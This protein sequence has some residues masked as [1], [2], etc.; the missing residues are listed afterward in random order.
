MTSRGRG[1]K[2]KSGSTVTTK[3]NTIMAAFERQARKKNCPVCNQSIFLTLYRAHLDNCK[4]TRNDSD[5]EVLEVLTAEESR[6]LRAGSPIVIET[7]DA[8][9]PTAASSRR[10]S[11]SKQE[12]SSERRRSKRIIT[13]SESVEEIEVIK[14]EPNTSVAA[15]PENHPPEIKRRS[16]SDSTMQV[17]S[18]KRT[19]RTIRCTSPLLENR[20]THSCESGEACAASSSNQKKLVTADEVV[21]KI[22]SLLNSSILVSPKKLAAVQEADGDASSVDV[23]R[24]PYIVKFTL[25]MMRRV[26]LAA[27]SDGGRYD[28]TF[29]GKDIEIFDRFIGL[30]KSARELFMRMHLRKPWWLTVEKLK[31]RYAELSPT[32]D[33]ALKELVDSGFV[34]SDKY[35]SSLEE[36][37]KIAPLPVLRV[38]AKKYQLDITK[39]KIELIST[40]RNFSAAQKGLFGQMGTVTVAMVKTVK[41]ELGSCYRINRNVSMTFKALF[42][43]YVP[44]EMCS[45]L[46]IDQPSLNLS[47]NLLFTLLRMDQ[48]AVQFPAP[49][50]CQN[51]ISIYDSKED[52][53]AYV[54]AKELEVELMGHLSSNKF[55]EAYECAFR[56][57]EILSSYSEESRSKA[58]SLAMP[59][60]RFTAFAI[61]TRCVAHGAGVLERQK[62]YAIAIS[63]QRFLLK[64]PELKPFC[65]NSRGALW[66]RLALNLDAHMKEREE[67]LQE[68][69]E[70]MED[71]VVADKDKLMLQD[72]AIRISNRDFLERIVL[73][74]PVKKEIHGTTL[75]KELGD[76]RIN[77]F[78][79]KDADGLVVECAVEEVVRKHYLD[80]E[81]FNNGVHAEGSIWH[82]VLGLLFYD[83]IFDHDVKD[84]WLS[85]LQGFHW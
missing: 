78:V 39:G 67:A 77:R 40:L 45:S 15:D 30:S 63:W 55:S 37:L 47:Q 61:L 8:C 31:E 50:P 70:G 20:P 41:K 62:K 65:T 60:R 14:V 43:L 28:E 79:L 23:K 38:V 52:L 29:W 33:T 49:N 66:D 64:T 34:D 36:V 27:K 12:K 48:G 13:R 54:E 71:G 19:K 25:L 82:T 56:A 74:E 7:E 21:Q 17:T 69:R 51:I 3:S 32:I 59:L 18:I 1:T 11:Q 76:S 85:E 10:L 53:L 75:S 84:V 80:K 4:I 46:V 9:E 81:D 2:Q 24:A 57:R 35:L 58:A 26:L 22:E 16:E 44:T 73:M 6:A 72:R 83:I 42:T 5:C 68:I